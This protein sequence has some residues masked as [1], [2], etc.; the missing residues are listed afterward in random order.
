LGRLTHYE[1]QLEVLV[2]RDPK[3]VKKPYVAPSFQLHGATAAKAA[4]ETGG[5][6]QDPQVEEMSVL[7]NRRLDE[8]TSTSGS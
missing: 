3:A 5:A 4:L 6:S 1:N 8:T 2:V 7:I